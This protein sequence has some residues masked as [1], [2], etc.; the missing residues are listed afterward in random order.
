M[1]A[2]SP[3]NASPKPDSAKEPETKDSQSPPPPVGKEYTSEEVE[4]KKKIRA[5]MFSNRKVSYCKDG[6][7]TSE[8]KIIQFL[9]LL[10]YLMCGTMHNLLRHAV[11]ARVINLATLSLS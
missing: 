3:E 6:H 2:A 9:V 4:K 11:Y 1:C 5:L 8:C 10:T 7:M